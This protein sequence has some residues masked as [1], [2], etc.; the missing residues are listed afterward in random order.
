MGKNGLKIALFLSYIPLLTAAWLSPTTRQSYSDNIRNI[1][2][3]FELHMSIPNSLDTLTS[4]LASIARLPFGVDVTATAADANSDSFHISK[5]YD[6]ESSRECRLVRERI[7]ELDLVVEKVIPAASN[8]RSFAGDF[9]A[10]LPCMIVSESGADGGLE[11]KKLVGVENILNYLDKIFG[12][13]KGK[14]AQSTN[15]DLAVL[16]GLWMKVRPFVDDLRSYLPS[17]FRWGRG[18]AV[19][20]CAILS[21]TPRPS[22][23]LVLY[24]YEGNQFCRLVREVLTELDLVYELRSAG[25]GSPRRAELSKITGG[26]T[27]CP[28]LVDPNT[29]T[30]ISESKDIIQYLYKNYA[31]WTPPNELLQLI[32]GLYTPVAKPVFAFL[33]PLQAGNY[34]DDNDMY[35]SSIKSA[36]SSIKKEI[37]SNPVVIY[38]YDLSPFSTEAKILLNNLNISYK[39]VSL[40][41]EWIP[42]LIANGGSEK[43]V[44]L[45]ELTGQTSLP[46][47]FVGG[48]S[49]GG[50]FSGNPGLIP[51]LEQGIF[52]D[53]V[54]A[55]KASIEASSSNSALVE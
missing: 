27:Q 9:E 12:I 11:E 42:G 31:K 29:E 1:N 28:F 14:L 46:N 19:A 30:E 43:R 41:K 6:V 55:A 38:T 51:T 45:G 32:S 3:K 18:N 35:N 24:S 33:A 54:S 47:L 39:E 13:G 22:K 15:D 40:G 52:L 49:I 50:L 8:S 37:E 2:K 10:G 26:S 53:M 25:K 48:K 21:D 4:G 5:L 44:A 7:T 23:P 17:F 20:S 36:K 16:K 34:E